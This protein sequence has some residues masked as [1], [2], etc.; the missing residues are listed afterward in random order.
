M[1]SVHTTP[2][3]QSAAGASRRTRLVRIGT[4]FAV[5]AVATLILGGCG[6]K[7]SSAGLPPADPPKTDA[8]ILDVSE[9][10]RATVMTDF[11]APASTKFAEAAMERGTERLCVAYGGGQVIAGPDKC[12]P[13][14]RGGSGPKAKAET[15]ELLRSFNGGIAAIGSQRSSLAGGSAVLEMLAAIAPALESG[16]RVLVAS[17]MI[18]NSAGVGDFAAGK[19]RFDDAGRA[20]ILSR[21]E[22]QKLLPDLDGVTV[23]TPFPLTHGNVP[24]NLDERRKGEI[25]QVWDEWADAT[26]A[27]LLWGGEPDA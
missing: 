22:T 19:L 7:D 26:G 16:S 6:D 2:S 15:A 11:Y 23:I 3:D 18:Q 9:S 13:I 4:A 25:H 21:L 10:V 24:S 14:E 27:T 1:V 17:D 8:V 5:G 20:E 12:M